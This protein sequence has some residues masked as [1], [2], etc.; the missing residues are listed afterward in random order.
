MDFPFVKWTHATFSD[1]DSC[2][3]HFIERYEIENLMN[4]QAWDYFYN[5]QSIFFSYSNRNRIKVIDKSAKHF[6]TTQQQKDG[7][8]LERK[9]NSIVIGLR[10][11]LS[12]SPPLPSIICEQCFSTNIPNDTPT[13]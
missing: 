3:N 1:I 8:F 9:K 11:P 10:S 7:I 2:G 13:R 12:S 4:I 5:L 6:T